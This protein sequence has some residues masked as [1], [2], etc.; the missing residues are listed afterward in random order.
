M[1][2]GLGLYNDAYMNWVQGGLVPA[3]RR[4]QGFDILGFGFVHMVT[5]L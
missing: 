2:M 5:I 1:Y 4:V 3:Y